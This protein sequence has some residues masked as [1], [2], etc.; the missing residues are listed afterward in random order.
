MFLN[1]DGDV[2]DNERK[3]PNR[4]SGFFYHKKANDNK[5]EFYLFCDCMEYFTL[6]SAA[7]L[8]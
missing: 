5:I 8:I 6:I 1:D 7:L 4:F 3:K 2:D